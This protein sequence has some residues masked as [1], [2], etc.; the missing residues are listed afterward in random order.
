MGV[1]ATP[2]FAQGRGKQ[3]GHRQG[4]PPGHVPPA[5][6]CRVWYDGVP[7]GQQPPPTSC[8]NAERLASRDRGARVVYG[9]GTR[10]N[11]PIYRDERRQPDVRYPGDI[12][13]E[14]ERRLPGDQRYPDTAG[15]RPNPDA[16]ER[17]RT[18]RAIPRGETSPNSSPY[19]DERYGQRRGDEYG[20]SSDAYRRGY[21]DGVTKA[22]EDVRDGDSFDPARHSWYRDGDRG[23]NSRYGSRDEYRSEYRRGFLAAYEATHDGRRGSS[24]PGWWPF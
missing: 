24:R 14:G 16:S 1:F 9:N 13:R 15:R 11:A 3:N 10:Q 5:G 6:M 12:W 8:S 18:G 17:N 21:D 22:R 19:P 20:Y 4:I 7:P 23:Y 2:A